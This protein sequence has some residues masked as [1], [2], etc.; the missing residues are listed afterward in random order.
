MNA[1]VDEPRSF[2]LAEAC[3]QRRLMLNQP[4]IKRL[5]EYVEH[6][7]RKYPAWEFQDFDPCD[8]G[9]DANILFLLE[10][11]GPKTS[12][13]SGEGSGFISRNNDDPTAEAIFRFMLEAGVP[14]KKTLL[15][16]VIP[17]WNGTRK[18]TSMERREGVDELRHLFPLIPKLRTVVLVG[19]QAGRAENLMQH[20]GLKI[21]KSSHPSPIV[22]ATNLAKW[23]SIPL[24]WKVAFD[25]NLSLTDQLVSS[26]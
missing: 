14:R 26:P 24:Q 17:G 15:W 7:R 1:Y 3:N 23:E 20:I 10:K 25:E 6:L 18:I 19:R 21:H 5:T 8:G 11:P 2:A 9:C 12:K 4:H 22:R 13:V 16:N